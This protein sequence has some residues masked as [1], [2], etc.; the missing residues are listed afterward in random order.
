MESEWPLLYVF[1][2]IDGV[3][4]TLPEQVE[5]YQR[6]LKARIYMDE[7]GGELDIETIGPFFAIRPH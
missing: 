5:E 3:F 6:L 1:M 7:N 2:I 4:R